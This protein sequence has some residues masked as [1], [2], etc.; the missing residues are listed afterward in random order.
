MRIGVVLPNWIGDTAMCTPMLRAL[1][2]HFGGAELV[3][4]LSPY[5]A[6][7]LAGTPWLDERILY[8]RR[9]RVATE[10]PLAV[11]QELRRR[12]FDAMVLCTNSFRAALMALYSGARERVGYV[13][14]GRG[15]L[16]THK[17]YY[18]RRGWRR[19]P[20]PA[21]DSYL[22]LAYALG[23]AYESPR[24]ELATLSADEDAADRVWRKYHLPGGNRVVV[25]HSGGAY[26][27]A[28]LWPHE[29]FAAL[30]RRI[31][32]E[33]DLAVLFTCGPDDRDVA[34]RMVALANHPRVVSLADDDISIG[35]SKACIRRSRLMVST[36]T[37]PRFFAVAFG[38]PLISL[39]GPTDMGWSRS[40][41]PQEICLQHA[42]PCGPCGKR[43]C[44]LG[45]HDC[46]R[47][48]SVERV[49]AAVCAQ[50][51]RRTISPAA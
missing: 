7:V 35:L 45:H 29:H 8:R 34:R 1:R 4:V 44:P 13:R 43:V 16:L 30:A 33:H 39:F 12:H 24:I 48:L 27:V 28:K 49:Y 32:T 20:T 50:L 31:A 11:A 51:E 47:L 15:A 42:V 9:S 40:H 36:D 46:M 19:L 3:G 25:M 14:Y 37:G 10:R 41:D 38:V 26:G 22:Q 17:L 2:H 18:P 21:I 5:V 6:D 23:C